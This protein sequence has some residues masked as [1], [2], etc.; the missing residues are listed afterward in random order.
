MS[1]TIK[2]TA[3]QKSQ[4]REVVKHDL[5]LVKTDLGNV[6]SVTLLLTEA[7]QQILK[8]ATGAATSKIELTEQDL[9]KYSSIAC[10]ERG[11]IVIT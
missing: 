10:Y 4:V 11:G 8:Q 7:Q 3:D 5:D 9:K 6:G 1:T 2:L